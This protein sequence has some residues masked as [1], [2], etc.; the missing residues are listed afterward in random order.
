[1]TEKRYRTEWIE[2]ARLPFIVDN[3]SAKKH[4]TVTGY[5]A[6]DTT[7]VKKCDELTDL[8]NNYEKECGQLKQLL[9]EVEHE[10]TSLTGLS[11]FDKCA[12]QLGYVE[13]FDNDRIDLDYSDLLKKIEKVILND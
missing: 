12:S 10:L 3:Y 13:V 9:R 6:Y 1:M 8:L 2:G 5:K 11:C 4:K 7:T